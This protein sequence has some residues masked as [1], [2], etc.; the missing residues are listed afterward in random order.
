[1]LKFSLQ[2]S[3]QSFESLSIKNVGYAFLIRLNWF[4]VFYV[5]MKGFL[6]IINFKRNICQ[7]FNSTNLIW[8]WCKTL[9]I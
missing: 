5:I 6:I 4:N 7:A 1:M 8:K 3:L 9:K 2:N